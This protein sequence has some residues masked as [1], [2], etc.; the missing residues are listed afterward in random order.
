VIRNEQKIARRSSNAMPN[1]N[2]DQPSAASTPH[3]EI[4]R[5]RRGVIGLRTRC[6]KHPMQP[7]ED[8]GSVRR[9][10]PSVPSKCLSRRQVADRDR[11]PTIARQ[12]HWHLRLGRSAAVVAGYGRAFAERL[13]Y[14]PREAR[15]W[16]EHGRRIRR[17]VP[18]K[19]T[20]LRARRR[21]LSA[22]A[23]GFAGP[24]AG[25]VT[26]RRL[27]SMKPTALMV[28][29]QSGTVIPRT[30]HWSNALPCGASQAWRR[31][32]FYETNPSRPT[33]PAAPGN[34]VCSR[35]R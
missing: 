25:I 24:R 7:R 27:A 14:G 19:E 28:K 20:I 23:A 34:V 6:G 32:T 10:C 16:H 21:H 4:M 11:Q 3:I 17:R 2:D 35:P 9:R 31:S 8:L 13:P 30:G 22:H 26:S 1:L 12:N 29:Y 15:L 33:P 18:A 5:T